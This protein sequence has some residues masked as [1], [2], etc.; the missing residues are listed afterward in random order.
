MFKLSSSSSISLLSIFFF[1]FLLL[2]STA[3][4]GPACALRLRKTTTLCI[5]EC[6]D[7]WGWPGVIMGTD[8]WGTVLIPKQIDKQII[9]AEACCEQYVSHFCSRAHSPILNP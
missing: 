5:A 3:E 7:G 9:I 1:F 6:Q 8:R 2:L 4:A